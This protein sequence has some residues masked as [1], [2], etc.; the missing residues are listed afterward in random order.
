MPCFGALQKIKIISILKL[1]KR[2]RVERI[3]AKICNLIIFALLKY[4]TRLLVFTNKR[5]FFYIFIDVVG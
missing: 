5:V 3:T 2:H 1:S 4:I